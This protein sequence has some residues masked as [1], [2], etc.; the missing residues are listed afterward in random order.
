M[1][2]IQRYIYIDKVMV[3]GAFKKVDNCTR[4]KEKVSLFVEEVFNA[5]SGKLRMKEKLTPL[6]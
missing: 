3:A 5:I 4:S 1:T 6:L 2:Y